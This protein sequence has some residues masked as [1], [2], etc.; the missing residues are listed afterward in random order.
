MR[1]I[2]ARDHGSLVGPRRRLGIAGQDGLLDEAKPAEKRV[3]VA[4]LVIRRLIGPSR[5][6]RTLALISNE[7]IGGRIVIE[8]G[9][10]TAGAQAT[11]IRSA[12]LVAPNDGRTKVGRLVVIVLRQR[13]LRAVVG[14]EERGRP[15]G[16]RR[17]NQR[18][19]A[20][21]TTTSL[22]HG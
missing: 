7:L 1:T 5:L 19:R 18:I 15:T 17:L 12:R 2:H 4:A 8:A 9:R 13:E 10:A 21:A 6:G 3:D 11:G 16:R 20:V 22:K 14:I